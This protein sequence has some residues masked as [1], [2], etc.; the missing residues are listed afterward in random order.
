MGSAAEQ[1]TGRSGVAE[2]LAQADARLG[3]TAPGWRT[4]DPARTRA[5]SLSSIGH[6]ILGG[7][8]DGGGGEGGPAGRDDAKAGVFA[9]ALADIAIATRDAF[10]DN[11]FWDFD[12]VGASLWRAPD[13]A[14][15]QRRAQDLV[16]LPGRY[17]RH[18][19][20][21][22]AYV[23]DFLYGFDW[24][25]WVA[26]APASRGH[27]APFDPALVDAMHT[28]AD[29][30][31]AAIEGGGDSK[32]PALADTRPRNPFG[33]GRAPHEEAR[34]LQVL[35]QRDLV[36]VRTW[37]LDGAPTRW[38]PWLAMRRQVAREL[39]L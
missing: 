25:K 27:V 26:R 9:Q 38:R 23:H 12:F 7:A 3:V 10:P 20:I 37:R 2:V 5:S 22:F 8:D 14:T 35:A 34:L 6:A 1:S 17:G 18:T 30:L 29:E 24:A 28:R 4:L 36:P 16:T 39:G 31:L 19:P 33:F 13:M 32:Y 11:L 21:A 15:L